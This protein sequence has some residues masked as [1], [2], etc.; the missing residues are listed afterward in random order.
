MSK[1]LCNFV[2][3]EDLLRERDPLVVRYALAAAH[4]RSSLDITGSTFDEAE[5]ALDRI[6][7]LPRA[8][9]CDARAATRTTCSVD[10][11]GPGCV[12]GGPRRRPRRAAGARGAPRNGARRQQ[13][14]G[15]RRTA[16]ARCARSRTSPSMTGV[17][18]IDPLDPHWRASDGAPRHPPSTRLVQTMITQRADARAAKDWAAADRI[19]DAIAAAGITLED[20]QTGRIGVSPT[21]SGEQRRGAPRMKRTDGQARTPRREQGQEEGPPRRTGGKNKRSLEGRGPTPKAEDRAWHPAG[22]RKAAAERYA[23]AGG[24][25]QARQPARG[26]RRAPR[27]EGRRHRDGHRS[28][29]GARG[30]AGEDP[31]DGVLHRAARRDGRPRQGDAGDRHPP[32]HPGPRGHAARARP[33]GRLRRRAPGR[34]PQGAAVRVRAPA[35]PARAGHRRAGRRRCSSRW[36]ASPIRAT[37][38]RSSAPPRRSA[39][40]ASS[41]RSAARRA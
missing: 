13:R 29:L 25:G 38:A 18:G 2:L 23:A 41:S 9:R 17:L 3:A 40:R 34:R 21:A 8:R 14:A 32:R 36:T 15:R 24:N 26:G 31:G 4:Y 19:R 27:E 33:H 12:R 37:S 5:A 20:S 22:K 10:R 6:R 39:G 11:A 7:T 28:Q 1:S 30:A 16:R 35:G